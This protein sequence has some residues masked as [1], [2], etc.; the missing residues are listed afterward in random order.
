MRNFPMLTS[1]N[2]KGLITIGGVFEACDIWTDLYFDGILEMKC[3]D[4]DLDNCSWLESPLNMTKII[5]ED[6]KKYNFKG[7]VDDNHHH[8]FFTLNQG[9]AGHV[10]FWIPEELDMCQ[11]KQDEEQ[12]SE[13]NQGQE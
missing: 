9:R 1:P 10:A 8:R 4:E 13:A 3:E 7:E 6:N 5:E 11:P 2:G 12:D